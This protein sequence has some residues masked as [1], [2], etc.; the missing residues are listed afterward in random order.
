VTL[1]AEW[2]EVD[3]IFERFAAREVVPGFAWG[4]VIDG[5]LAH[6]GSHGTLRAGE[7][8][9]P[10][11]DSVFRIASMTK[12]FTAATVLLLRDEGRLRL[13][14]PVADWLPE[15]AG[16]DGP[17]ADSPPI[18]I[19]HL[20]TM[21]GGLPTDD[22]WGDRQQ[23]L[24]LDRFAE[25]LAGGLSFAWAPDNRFEYSNLGYGVLGRIV[26]RAAGAEYRDVVR[27]RLLEPLGMRDTTYL[28]DEVPAD[29]LA[30]GWVRRDDAWI[31]EP[32][33]PYGALA[34]MGGV[35]TTV[36]DLARWVAGFTAAFPP[37][38]EPPDAHPL[39]RATRREM[40]Q[41]YRHGEPELRWTTTAAAPELQAGGYG[42]GLFCWD[43]LRFGRFVGH[44]GG[45][46]GFGSHMRWHTASGIGVI[47]FGNARYA[48][49]GQPV[50][51]ALVALVAA[52]P[53]RTR[54]VR[55]W[56]ETLAARSTVERL[57]AAW[58]DDLAKGLFAM[59]I[60]LDEPLERRRVAIERLSVTH[61]ALRP[62]DSDEPVSHSPAHLAWWMAG[63]RG[64][65]Q[66]DLLM[67][68]ERPPRVQRFAVTSV[69]EPTSA[70][71]AIAGRVLELLRGPGPAWPDDLGLAEAVDRDALGRALRAA[72]AGWG[73]LV[74]GPV[75]AGD[76]RTVA[77][78]R[79]QGD[80]GELELELTLATD[81]GETLSAVTMV[82]RS[83]VPPD[84]VS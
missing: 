70:L 37:R 65:V 61:G 66:I 75:I 15:L 6:H 24:P 33:D 18:T 20:L 9:P 14:D 31:P 74:L 63:D 28:P 42:Y 35:L 53:R 44:G 12:S 19:R 52:R 26:T 10:D 47:G 30:H 48:P 13:D 43:D 60:E 51:E 83:M 39:T 62:D 7:V 8:A 38:D 11:L 4:V 49:V 57:L 79:L 80:R 3:A 45:Y 64:R 17:T 29:R 55:P 50:R 73:P 54:R 34:P 68:P 5:E 40:Q 77:R 84:V 32:I 27:A 41:V 1:P 25:L 22:P 78:W 81:G 2:A 59:N 21:S 36:R 71:A 67:S 72:E 58:D 46:P 76:G 82:P 23:G 16:L 56:P 69:P